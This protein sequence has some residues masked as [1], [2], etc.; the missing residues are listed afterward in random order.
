MIKQKLAVCLAV[1]SLSSMSAQAADVE[2]LHWWTS[3]GE[4]RSVAYLKEKLTEWG[5]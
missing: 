1:A 5:Y 2:V 4:A 3:G